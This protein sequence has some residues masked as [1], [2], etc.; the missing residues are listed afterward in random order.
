MWIGV[1]TKVS[2]LGPKGQPGRDEI[3]LLLTDNRNTYLIEAISL[4]ND[5]FSTADM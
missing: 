2:K 5:S 1:N 4:A 3:T